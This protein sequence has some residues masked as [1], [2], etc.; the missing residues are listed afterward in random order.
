M[1]HPVIFF[2]IQ[3]GI[4]LVPG[5]LGMITIINILFAPST[6]FSIKKPFHFIK[7]EFSVSSFYRYPRVIWG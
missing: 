3:K 7:L 6:L 4:P 2:L 5:L 1:G